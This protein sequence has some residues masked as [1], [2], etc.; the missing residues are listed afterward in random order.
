MFSTFAMMKSPSLSFIASLT[1]LVGANAFT[2]IAVHNN[3]LSRLDTSCNGVKVSAEA[4][5]K[6]GYTV[7]VNKPL[8]VVFGENRAPYFGL[9]V[10]DVE[11][12]LNG[13]KAGMRVGDQLLSIDGKPVVG[14]DF[15]STMNALRNAPDPIELDLF[16]GTV[17]QLYTIMMNLEG[18]SELSSDDV[19]DDDED[20]LSDDLIVMDEDY[21]SP[22]QIDVSQFE[23]EQSI[24]ES[25]SNVIK[26]LGK[27]FSSND[28]EDKNGK[29]GGAKKG[30][31]FGGMFS[32]ET[33]QLDFEDGK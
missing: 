32:K 13:G 4:L 22:V 15:D 8:G 11:P 24:Q 16:R 1:L 21:E 28:D 29:S 27:I 9:V 12:G 33:I 20:G 30:G 7:V 5:A 14:N 3:K 31:L 10:D 23:N 2:N 25:A 26:N 6:I 19:D 17:S 18:I